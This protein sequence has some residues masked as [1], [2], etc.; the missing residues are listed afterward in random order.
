VVLD[1]EED[2]ELDKKKSKKNKGKK[3]WSTRFVSWIELIECLW[4]QFFDS[5]LDEYDSEM[6]WA[7]RWLCMQQL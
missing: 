3:F 5:Q 6:M 1:L 2:G 4:L 7:A